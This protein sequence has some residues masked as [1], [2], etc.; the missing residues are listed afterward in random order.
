[1]DA[2]QRNKVLTAIIHVLL[3]LNMVMRLVVGAE[4]VELLNY[5]MRHV[6]SHVEDDDIVNALI[7][8]RIATFNYGFRRFWID[9]RSCH[10]I[11]RVLDG[12]L[13]QGGQ[14]DRAFRMSR[15]SFEALHG[16]LGTISELP[17]F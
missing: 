2:Q 4:H 12:M 6:R 8:F 14:F 10:W 11:N 17:S 5:G 15:N 13:L 9:A 3:S 16:I 7:A 1:M